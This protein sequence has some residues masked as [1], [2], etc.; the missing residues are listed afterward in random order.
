MKT[1]AELEQQAALQVVSLMAAA[2]RTAPKTRGID[3]IRVVAI[4]DDVSKEKITAKMK[5]LAAS[6]NRPT[7]NRDAACVSASPAVLLIG[8]ALA[9]GPLAAISVV[10]LTWLFWGRIFVL[11]VLAR[12]GSGW[13]CFCLTAVV[14]GV[15]C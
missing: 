13:G 6:E 12:T 8:M 3:N 7:F 5:E 10:S 15:G 2:A 4:D 14:F 9:R 1:S 11:G